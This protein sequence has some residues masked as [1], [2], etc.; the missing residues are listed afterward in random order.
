MDL[1]P[2]ESNYNDEEV[3]GSEDEA[4][5]CPIHEVE[6]DVED[7]VIESSSFLIHGVVHDLTNHLTVIAHSAELAEM[8]DELPRYREC[9]TQ[10]A[11]ACDKAQTAIVQIG[12]LA[13]QRTLPSSIFDLYVATRLVARR[14]RAWLPGVDLLQVS[15]PL[16]SEAV[17]NIFGNVH[18]IH[19]LF[20]YFSGVIGPAGKSKS[21]RTKLRIKMEPIEKVGQRACVLWVFDVID[22]TNTPQFWVDLCRHYS[23]TD[24]RDVPQPVLR[25]K[26]ILSKHRAQLEWGAELKGLRVLWPIAD[27]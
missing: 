17:A 15:I 21:P 27:E 26:L 3:T 1:I 8:I 5:A 13:T 24:P 2:P 12:A 4:S 18:E 22:H 10:I 11:E 6:D 9:C 14:V 7:K 16:E 19:E 20:L 23:A 25:A